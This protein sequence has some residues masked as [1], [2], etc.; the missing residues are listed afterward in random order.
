MVHGLTETLLTVVCLLVCGQAT[1]QNANT[2]LRKVYEWVHGGLLYQYAQ[3]SS[4]T[5]L[6]FN[7]PFRA[8]KADFEVHVQDT[9]ND[10]IKRTLLLSLRHGSI[11]VLQPYNESVPAS[12]VMPEDQES[13]HLDTNNSH[14]IISEAPAPG[15]LYMAAS[16]LNPLNN[17]VEYLRWGDDMGGSF[18]INVRAIY[19]VRTAVKSLP[20]GDVST[21][22]VVTGEA[23]TFGFMVPAFTT[24]YSIV[25]SNCGTNGSSCPVTMTTSES[26]SVS[27]QSAVSVDCR[28]QAERCVLTRVSPKVEGESFVTFS[29]DDVKG[30]ENVTFDV[31]FSM[32]GCSAVAIPYAERLMTDNG[33]EKNQPPQY[34]YLTGYDV[35]E[36]GYGV[37]DSPSCVNLGPLGR[38]SKSSDSV[39]NAFFG[40]WTTEGDVVPEIALVVPDFSVE[41]RTFTIQDSVDTGGILSILARVADDD[42]KGVIWVCAMAQR[43]GHNGSL[44]ECQDGA[45]LTLN[46]TA[47]TNTSAEHDGVNEIVEV[48]DEALL[49]FP[50]AG[51]WY[52][53]MQSQCLGSGPEP[54]GVLPMIELTV[55]MQQ[56]GPR[57]CGDY[58][59]CQQY[60][61]GTELYASCEC[62]SGYRG[63]GCN[64]GTYGL[65]KGKQMTAVYLLTLSNLAF[66][67]AIVLALYRRF[68]TLAAVFF[69][70]SF[71]SAFYHACD[72]SKVYQLC[73]M[74]YGTLAFCDFFG[75]LLSFY[76][77]FLTMARISDTL[78]TF[79]LMSGALIISVFVTEDRHNEAF[80]LTPLFVSG[81]VL[82]VSWVR[83]TRLR[84][85]LYPSKGRYLRLLL[86][87]V[88]LAVTGIGVNY[89]L[90]WHQST[91][92]F[93]HSFWHFA[94][95]VTPLFLMPPRGWHS[96]VK[97]GLSVSAQ[98]IIR[99]GM[100]PE[101]R[102]QQQQPLP[103]RQSVNID[104]DEPAMFDASMNSISSD[105]RNR[106]I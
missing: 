39:F 60:L 8:V 33:V 18:Q 10:G 41:V 102:Q 24:A 57:G 91:Y 22:N 27:D 38:Y 88:V 58:G 59:T 35:N 66:I 72:T 61:Q 15:R 23:Q 81:I 49:P 95:M 93:T 7:V 31:S 85:K 28:Q 70:N 6:V 90:M 5:L 94:L 83:E 29:L 80:Q 101:P 36:A 32:L 17:V 45:L 4:F 9:S 20:A 106:L 79:L 97:R 104:H 53:T 89:G 37:T 87:G 25:V 100:Q 50:V 98:D 74:N 26:L 68:Y 62:H 54:C 34:K 92:Q 3:D 105:D 64:D 19:T 42:W 2:G 73:I 51:T 44:S 11:P 65:S 16:I 46:T 43:V 1:A 86:P 14:N 55:T 77:L 12:F 82:V 96:E 75:S 48:M 67:P 71:F 40:M 103:C 76:S 13:H 99:T 47:T 69:F 78:R 56:C 84:G 30:I 52:L 21:S 63:L